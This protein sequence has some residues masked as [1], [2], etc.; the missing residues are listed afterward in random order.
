LKE[1]ASAVALLYPDLQCTANE[2]F[3]LPIT[4]TTENNFW[5]AA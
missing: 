3:P 1:G 2:T 4:G 5:V